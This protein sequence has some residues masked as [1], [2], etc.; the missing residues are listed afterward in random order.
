MNSFS[1]IQYREPSNLTELE[2]LLRLRYEVYAEDKYLNQMVSATASFDLNVFDLNAF[3]F[4]GFVDGKP[5]AYIRITNYE[6]T[7]FTEWIEQIVKENRLSVQS[8]AHQFPFQSYYPD[9]KWSA[10]FVASLGDKK[11]GEVGK[12]AIHKMYRKSGSV[13]FEIITAF[14]K[15]CK[16]NKAYEVGFGVCVEKLARYYKRFGFEKVAEAKP[17]TYGNLP[18][19]VLVRFDK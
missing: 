6:K 2:A 11:V 19:A 13:L 16:I 8:S 18:E 10:T 5:I 9:S 7:E 4:G 3:H 14:L 15:Y 12:L 1:H 17:F